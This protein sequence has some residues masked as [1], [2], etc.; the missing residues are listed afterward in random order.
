M[1]R[2]NESLRTQ[3]IVY[4]K[5]RIPPEAFCRVFL[6]TVGEFDGNANLLADR[7]QLVTLGVKVHGHLLFPPDDHQRDR[8]PQQSTSTD[9]SAAAVQRAVKAHTKTGAKG[10]KPKDG[11]WRIGFEVRIALERSAEDAHAE[12]AAVPALQVKALA[13][14]IENREDWE[15]DAMTDSWLHKGDLL[16]D[17][18][19]LINDKLQDAVDETAGGP[20]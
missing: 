9:S 6:H 20:S 17:I 2:L 4:K 12:D 10:K 5:L 8:A 11:R 16:M 1:S 13:I 14:D 7:A 18:E 15:G 19:A 3:G